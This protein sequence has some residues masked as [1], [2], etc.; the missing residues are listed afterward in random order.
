MPARLVVPT[1]YAAVLTGAAAFTAAGVAMLWFLLRDARLPGSDLLALAVAAFLVNFLTG[2]PFVLALVLCAT[3]VVQV[4]AH[5]VLLRRHAPWTV[6]ARPRID[7]LETLVTLGWTTA[8][9]AGLAV[10]L[11]GAGVAL[12]TQVPAVPAELAVWFG[13]LFA[14]SV[15]VVSAG[16]VAVQCWQ[17][18]DRAGFA[19]PRRPREAWVLAATTLAAMAA[20]FTIELPL[21]FALVVP[22]VWSAKRF[23]TVV[24]A[25]ISL[26]AGCVAV[27]CTLEGQ[28]PFSLID[29]PRLAA[30][31]V[32]AY[33]AILCGLGL[34]VAM[35]RDEREVLLLELAAAHDE[36]RHQ[37]QLLTKIVDSMDEGVTAVDARGSVLLQNPAAMRMLDI[38]DAHSPDQLAQRGLTA[39]GR[40][41]EHDQRPSVRALRGEHV[42]ED[43]L[44]TRLDGSARHLRVSATPLEALSAEDVARAVMIFRDVTDEVEQEAA[45]KAFAATVAHDLHNPLAAMIGWNEVMLEMLRSGDADP[46]ELVRLCERLGGSADRLQELVDGLLED[47]ASKGRELDLDRVELDDVLRDV[48][49]S[50][51]AE[52]CVSWGPLPAVRADRLLTGQLLDNLVGNALKYVAVGT[53]PRVEV[54]ADQRSQGWVT[55]EVADN[56]IGIPDG[57]HE[58]V[59]E[60]FARAHD[61]DPAYQ[62]TGLGLA[63]VKRIVTRHDGTVTARPGTD[64]VGTVVEFTL[65]AA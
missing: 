35:A 61:S 57:E 29:D 63:I 27:V 20:V 54:T 34:F 8:V 32:Q 56:G 53:T 38:D 16:I 47:A 49:A 59:F 15:V 7:D 13:R 55:V 14:G 18:P 46:A 4:V 40:R 21:T 22:V 52:E 64:G 51:G 43:L 31:T 3:N 5:L 23:P 6:G 9:A 37:A 26:A 45:L 1:G 50:R 25:G 11:G 24:A 17:S 48:A 65:P 10:A 62:G 28:G 2:A 30:L 12:V 60:R 36:T 41:I 39:R 33:V 42:H 58:H 19:L 44:M